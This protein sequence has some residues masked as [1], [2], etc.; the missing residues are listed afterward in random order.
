VPHRWNPHRLTNPNPSETRR[1][2]PSL[3]SSAIWQRKSHNRADP[4]VKSQNLMK[5]GPKSQHWM[6]SG[7]KSQ[8]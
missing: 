6:N 5:S 2:S 3:R 1:D 8:N 4:D 7:V